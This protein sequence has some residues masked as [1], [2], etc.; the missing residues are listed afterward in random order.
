MQSS[1][2][3]YGLSD[4]G[5]NRLINQ[6]VWAAKPEWGFFVLADGMGGRRAGDVAAKEAVQILCESM[7]Q[8]WETTRQFEDKID[9]SHQLRESIELA[10]RWVY[11]MG[12]GSESL[13]GMGTTICCVLW[14]DSIIYYAHVGDSR[15]YRF[16]ND[17]LELLT[18]DH[19][20]LARWL[21][22]KRPKQPTPPKNIITRAI[23]TP[24]A[25]N[26]E[27]SFSQHDPQD[28]YLLCSDGLSDAVSKDELQ[29]IL[30]NSRSMDKAA[31]KM[32]DCAKIM[33]GGD[34]ITVLMI[35]A[36]EEV[37]LNYNN[38]SLEPLINNG[39]AL[40]R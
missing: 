11:K 21:S 29:K 7:R 4:I 31:Q 2:H 34:N 38:N 36:A 9:Y 13:H 35:S 6:D 19:S 20:L 8:L 37:A 26:P 18:R 16:R 25:A 32:I 17:R 28:L 12:C 5:L 1:L 15:I 14:T 23:G 27:I 10:N 30:R 33:G 40:P 3:Y 22:K 39:T 24:R